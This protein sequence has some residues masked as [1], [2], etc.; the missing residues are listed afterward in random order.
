MIFESKVCF[1]YDFQF[2]DFIG[3]INV[4]YLRS[5][6]LI[7]EEARDENDFTAWRWLRV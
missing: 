6:K 2:T 3:L 1:I 5:L 4:N 7:G